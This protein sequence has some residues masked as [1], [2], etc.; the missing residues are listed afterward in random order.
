MKDPI[1][2]KYQDKLY[3]ILKSFYQAHRLSGTI[4][5][6]F[7]LR[8]LAD[9]DGNG[10]IDAYVSPRD[11]ESANTLK[12]E[13]NAPHMQFL[14]SMVPSAVLGYQFVLHIIPAGP[15]DIQVE[16]LETIAPLTAGSPT[17]PD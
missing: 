11:Q 2:D 4:K 5:L 16:H 12:L 1:W 14:E 7:G 10:V 9:S 15:D 17:P 8:A 6:K 13:D 3:R